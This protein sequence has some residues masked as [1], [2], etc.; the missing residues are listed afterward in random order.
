MSGFV[1]KWTN[2][3]NDK[4]YI[5]SHRGSVDDGYIASGVFIRQSIEKHGIENFHREILYVG[6]DF[7]TREKEILLELDAAK[8]PK[9]YNM[10]NY[11][12]DNF[13]S[14]RLTGDENPAKRPEV[15]KKLSQSKK[16][17]YLGEENSQFGTV[18]LYDPSTN[19][20]LKVPKNEVND[21]LKKNWVK[22]RPQLSDKVKKTISQKLRGRK[23]PPRS[24]EHKSNLS[25]ARKGVPWSVAR[26]EAYEK[27]KQQENKK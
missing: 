20:T 5:G 11:A 24:E 1:Y 16:G 15:R 13:P 7:R 26:R 23:K 3:L 17:K 4:W 6:E 18:W 10:I 2:L 12:G 19:Q 27:R 8:D 21:Y 9:S 14:K 25:A 22:G